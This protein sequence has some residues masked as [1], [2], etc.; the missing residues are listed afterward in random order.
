M[1]CAPRCRRPLRFDL[2]KHA[3]RD[4]RAYE[5]YLRGR[6]ASARMTEITMEQA[7][8]MFRRAIELDPDY[9]QAHA[10]LSDSLCD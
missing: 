6:Q 1:R 5:F 7:P 10:G 4:M 9:A 3:P 8:T 2:K